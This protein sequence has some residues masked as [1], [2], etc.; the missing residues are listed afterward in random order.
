MRFLTRS[1]VG[2][3]LLSLTVGLLGLGGLILS[4]AITARN[5]DDGPSRPAR[6]RVYAASVATLTPDTVIPSLSVYGEIRSRRTLEVR[7][8]SAGT[9][10]A[11]HP[12]FE[13]GGRVAAGDVLIQIDPADAE[14][15]LQKVRTDLDEARADLRDAIRTL[16]LAVDDVSAAQAQL[17]LRRQALDRQRNLQDR[18]VGTEA[19][20]E[21]AELAEAAAVQ[22]LLSR[23]Q[24]LATAEARIDLSETRVTR[25]EIEVAEAARD[26]AD[27]TLAA[28]F[29]GTLTATTAVIGGLVT[30][31]EQI[32]QLV[33]PTALEVAFRTSAAQ[34][35]RLLGPD[36]RLRQTDV[37]VTLDVLGEAITASGRLTRAAAL[38]GEGQ[39]GRLL[40]AQLSEAPAFRPGDFVTVSAP[41]PELAG[42]VLL[43]SSAVSPEG[44]VLLLGP[45]DRLETGRVEIVRR[46]GDDLIVRV[47]GHAGREVVTDRSPVLGAG[48]KIRPVRPEADLTTAAAPEMLELDAERRAR[49]ISFVEGNTRMPAAAKARVLGQL[50]QEQVPAAVVA[51]IESRMGG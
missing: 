25:R 18:G 50:A 13:E 19:T 20:V 12:A 31:N 48:I 32:A 35:L 43:P 22:A 3:V 37:S 21:V 28:S 46:Q 40:F 49:L 14:T 30:A 34:Y 10:L 15:A 16:E 11:L 5:A 47:A 45:E 27:T 36:G 29:D 38:V 7:A 4:D 26:L 6:E 33:D 17:A 42:V 9:V 23:R 41:E 44:G 1:L 8:P 39:T 24:A 51:R 2:L